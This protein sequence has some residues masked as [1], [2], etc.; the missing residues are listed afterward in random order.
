MYF[1]SSNVFRSAQHAD[2]ILRQQLAAKHN[3][4]LGTK[5]QIKF[6]DNPILI[7]VRSA[8]KALM[9]QKSNIPFSRKLELEATIKEYY[10]VATL[11]KELLNDTLKIG[12]KTTNEAFQCVHGEKVVKDIITEGCLFDFIRMWRQ[13]FLDSMQPKY[14][15]ELWSVDHNAHKYEALTKIS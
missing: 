8:A 14:L 10:G 7:K 6:I 13:H 4:P 12:V 2:D 3:A 9:N 15:P 11:D 5:E 1:Y